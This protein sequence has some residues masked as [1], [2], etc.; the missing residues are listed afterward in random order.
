MIACHMLAIRESIRVWFI[1]TKGA[2]K[3]EISHLK[4]EVGEHLGL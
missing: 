2:K 1:Y 4:T 3:F